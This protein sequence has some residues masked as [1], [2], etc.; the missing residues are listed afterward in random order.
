MSNNQVFNSILVNII[1]HIVFL[2]E[3]T[4]LNCEYQFYFHN[5]TSVNIYKSKHE[6]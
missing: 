1:T 2:Q 6:F 3:S 5:I 4:I